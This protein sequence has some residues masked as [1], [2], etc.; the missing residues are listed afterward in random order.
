MSR[1]RVDN[2][3]AELLH[4]FGDARADYKL[5]HESRFRPRLRGV[6]RQGSGADYHYRNEAAFYLAMEQAREFDRN[7]PI[8][9]PGIT[10]CITNI[11]QGGFKNDVNTGDKELDKI[12]TD[13]WVA[14]SEDPAQ[15][16][17]EK[18]HNFNRLAE[19]AYRAVIVDG[20]HL[21]LPLALGSL[22]MVEAHRLRTPRN[23][24]K[25]QNVVH[26]LKLSDAAVRQEYWITKEDLG[27]RNRPTMIK[28]IT[29]VQAWDADGRRSVL[30]LYDPK[31][32]SQ[33]RGVSALA[34]VADTAGMFADTQFAM[35]VKQQ[36][37]SC[38]AIFRE[39]MVGALPNGQ[40]QVGE[41][42]TEARPDGTTRVMEGLAP[43][44]EIFGYEGEKLQGFSPNIPGD[45]FLQHSMLILTVIAINLGVPVAVLL[46]DPS[47]T[48][49]SGWR[50]AID[51]A[52][53]GW[54]K[55]QDWFCSAFHRP[56]YQWKVLQWIAEDPRLAK[57]LDRDDVNIFGHTWNKPKWAYIEPLK[58]ITAGALEMR[59]M[60]TSPRR[61]LAA[62]G[63]IWEDVVAEIVAD[64][65]LAIRAA[66]EAAQKIN[67]DYNDGHP[68]SW[69]QLL[70]LPMPEG[71]SLKMGDEP[72]P[73]PEN[74]DGAKKNAA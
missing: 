53:K 31:R 48:N 63:L 23:A 35:L 56:V 14:W 58:D 47:N 29:K 34:P 74:Q 45:G 10:R 73:T 22:Q 69:L 30:H 71:V 64:N 49:F 6:D 67:K 17:S 26:G 4:S 7:D 16:H 72:A 44:L 61:S 18:E 28:E 37:A 70:A 59:T 24:K 52:R 15:C 33:R 42:E 38:F 32:T 11:F 66:K 54:S 13:K 46:L 19:L 62:R 12:L 21:A 41:R 51:E 68:V 3:I 40:S 39:L 8:V 5:G 1:R 60:Q 43:G 9:G 25:E 65:M 57:Y 36:V 20:D 55:Q 27:T 50:G 2:P